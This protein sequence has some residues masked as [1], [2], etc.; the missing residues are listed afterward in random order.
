ML[1]PWSTPSRVS[2]RKRFERIRQIA[3]QSDRLLLLS[4]T[5]LLHN[6][7]AFQAMLHMLD[8]VIY[9]LGNM[10]A[11]RERVEDW[12]Q[13]AE[14]FHVFTE[15]EAGLSL[16][17]I[18][19]QINSM[20]P[21]D[22][23]LKAM[24]KELQPFLEFDA[25][26]ENPERIR[27]IRA[28]RTHIS[29]TYR[30]HRRLLRNR[31]GN[32]QTETLLPG[33]VGLFV[34]EYE[35]SVELTLNAA[36][37]QWRVAAATLAGK[38]ESPKTL[39]LSDFFIVMTEAIHDPAVLDAILAVRLEKD[40]QTAK[41]LGVSEADIAAIKAAP[42]VPGEE[43]ILKGLRKALAGEHPDLSTRSAARPVAENL[44]CSARQEAAGKD[45]RVCQPPGHGRSDLCPSAKS[46]SCRSRAASRGS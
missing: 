11:F 37:E 13:T 27:L 10:V 28:I 41:T 31:R 40:V 46:V 9:R 36:L 43:K 35:D 5:P 26:V 4:A 23:H 19:N 20:F 44:E 2:E 42:P 22:A 38:P 39:R 34:Q 6:E 32:D 25:E 24:A 45:C 15:S 1:P 18:L 12:Q 8:P 21:F 30:L 3:L 7:V 17:T 16:E 29:E 14:L 33:R